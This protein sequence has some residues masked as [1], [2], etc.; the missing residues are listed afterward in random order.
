[1]NSWRAATMNTYRFTAL[2]TMYRRYECISGRV[3]SYL[4]P[5][6]G[7]CDVMF[8]DFSPVCVIPPVKC[9]KRENDNQGLEIIEMIEMMR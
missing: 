5:K 7:L 1:M 6:V 9:T 4:M 3:S 2:K 8:D